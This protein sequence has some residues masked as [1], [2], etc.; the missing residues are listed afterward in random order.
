MEKKNAVSKAQKAKNPQKRQNAKTPQKKKRDW[1]PNPQHN[2][3]EEN[4]EPGDITKYLKVEMVALD[5]PP[6]DISDPAQV[7]CRIRDY[8]GFCA[9]NDVLPQFVGMALWLGVNRTTLGRWKRGEYRSETHQPIMEKVSMMM[10][11]LWADFM[12]ANKMA[13]GTGIFMGK[14]WY[15]YRD[16]QDVVVTPNQPLGELADQK[17]I[18][19]RISGTVILEDE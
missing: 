18:E 14:N 6:V 16:V 7:E 2:F 17:A 5:L 8:I 13:P 10:E 15:G 19:E 12:Q 11:A 4:A 9:Q 1:V 3:G